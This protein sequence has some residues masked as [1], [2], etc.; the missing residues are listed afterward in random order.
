[1]DVSVW[2][3]VWLTHPKPNGN[4]YHANGNGLFKTNKWFRKEEG[5]ERESENYA[6]SGTTILVENPRQ[7]RE[8]QEYC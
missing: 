3:S 2:A 6:S 7:D 8:A 1:M 5:K 4:H